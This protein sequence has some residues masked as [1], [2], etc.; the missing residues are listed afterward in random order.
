MYPQNAWR[1]AY[2][3]GCRCLRCVEEKRKYY[4][5]YRK[6]WIISPT[7]KAR[8]KASQDKYRFS[9]KG[10]DTR[11]RY[12]TSEQGKESHKKSKM[13]FRVNNPLRYKEQK[14]KNYTKY[15]TTEKFREACRRYYRSEKGRASHNSNFAKRKQRMKCDLTKEETQKIRLIYEECQRLS[16]ET[17]ILHHVDHI[18]P[19]ALGGLHHPSN[20][21]ILTAEE[22]LKKGCKLIS[23]AHGSP[24]PDASSPC[25]Q[26]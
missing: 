13:K 7:A 1:T 2:K 23:D 22:N 9:Q 21:Q 24:Q 6:K 17:G 16:K 18:I 4:R 11:R 5:E 8:E 20:L 14:K 10:K 3:K 19:L 26:G 15:H 25:H 12:N